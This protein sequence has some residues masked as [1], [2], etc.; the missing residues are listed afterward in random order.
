MRLLPEPK[1]GQ[2]QCAVSNV[3]SRD[4]TAS[5]ISLQPDFLRTQFAFPCSCLAV[6]D[7]A[8]HNSAVCGSCCVVGL[9]WW[10]LIVRVCLWWFPALVLI[11]YAFLTIASLCNTQRR[12]SSLLQ[13]RASDAHCLRATQQ[14][15]RMYCGSCYQHNDIIGR[16]CALSRVR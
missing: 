12:L 1:L 14:L 3:S 4:R 11:A 13:C 8:I 9:R 15:P 2:T 6:C 5:P 10:A 16:C 7:E